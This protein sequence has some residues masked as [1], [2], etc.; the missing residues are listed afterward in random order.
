LDTKT[1]EEAPEASVKALD[2]LIPSTNEDSILVAFYGGESLLV[3]ERV[4]LIAER[5]RKGHIVIYPYRGNEPKRFVDEFFYLY[6]RELVRGV[7]FY[8]ALI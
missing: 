1:W 4:R 6:Q 3:F 8:P 7:R 5:L 2:W